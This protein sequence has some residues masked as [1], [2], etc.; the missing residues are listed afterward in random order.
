MTAK[1]NRLIGIWGYPDPA[2]LQQIKNKYPQN[3][4]IDLDINYN[5]PESGVFPDAYCRIMRNIVNNAV[6]FRADLDL[7][8]ASVGREKCDAGWFAASIL[9]D[10]GF[11]LIETK[12]EEYDGKTLDTPISRSNLPL[13]D[14]ITKIMDNV[15]QKEPI[16]LTEVEPGFGFWGVPPHDMGFLEIFPD[17]THVY[18]W[19]RCV[20]A[21]RPAEIELEM[22]VDDN[23]P[24]VFFAQTFCAKM[25]L[26]KYL[27]QKYNGIYIDV[28]D[29]ASNS[30]KAKIEAFIKLG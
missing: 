21:G 4:F 15:I 6:A 13:K 10:M 9:K 8:L 16:E 18:G 23:V 1:N 2:V 22:Y 27:A 11:N 7:I 29:V 30:V 24:T 5:A 3:R 12:Y 25:Q 17:N 20:E 26:A 19:T 14:K 28:D